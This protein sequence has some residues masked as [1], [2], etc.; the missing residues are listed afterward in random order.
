[1]KALEKPRSV[2]QYVVLV[3][4]LVPLSPAVGA[5]PELGIDATRALLVAYNSELLES[6]LPKST[7]VLARIRRLK[8]IESRV[9]LY[10]S[11]DSS[12]CHLGGVFWAEVCKAIESEACVPSLV[13]GLDD[14]DPGWR[15]FSS[16]ALGYL[17]ARR[18]VPDLLELLQDQ[19]VV[20]LACEDPRTVISYAGNPSVAVFASSALARMG[21]ADGIDLL[22]EHAARLK[23][24]FADRPAILST[25]PLPHVEEFRRLSS[26]DFGDE[27]NDLEAWVQWFEERK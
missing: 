20:Q 14:P 11:R 15:S 10:E 3:S 26:Q 22:L 8:P 1:M 21:R 16:E 5:E 24:E 25:V 18:V 2:F 13:R 9:A 19:A 27:F 12:V 4:L 17:E 23:A 6:R 7:N